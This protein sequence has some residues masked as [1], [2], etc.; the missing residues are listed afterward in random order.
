MLDQAHRYADSDAYALRAGLAKRLSVKPEELAFGH[1]SNELI[2]LLCR[3]FAG[4][5]QHAVIGT[6][7]FA[8][9]RLSLL[10]AQVPFAKYLMARR[11]FD[12]A[13]LDTFT[14]DLATKRNTVMRDAALPLLE[15]GKVFIAVGALHLLGK[16]GLVELLR[17]AGYRVTAVE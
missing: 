3:T 1:G 4:P 5:E 7:S 13:M 12:P 16:D 17:G 9:Y 11:G 15:R 2:D 8:C 6:P 10:A 14:R